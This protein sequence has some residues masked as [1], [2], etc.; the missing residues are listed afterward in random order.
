[1][2]E[3]H[4]SDTYKCN[5]NLTNLVKRYVTNG[6]KKNLTKI[7]QCAREDGL[8]N[9]RKAEVE[10]LIQENGVNT[11]AVKHVHK[12]EYAMMGDNNL[13]KDQFNQELLELTSAMSR[14]L[15]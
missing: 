1:M 5:D 8:Q 13:L 6:S 7:K 4:V 11:L 10:E 15:L 12:E 9:A 3:F 2:K 14:Y